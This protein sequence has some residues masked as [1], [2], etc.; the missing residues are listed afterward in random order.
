MTAAAADGQPAARPPA[1]HVHY[2]CVCG[3][4]YKANPLISLPPPPTFPDPGLHQLHL[5]GHRVPPAGPDRPHLHLR[6]PHHRPLGLHP[7]L[8]Q[9]AA[10]PVVVALQRLPAA[11]QELHAQV[12][13]GQGQLSGRHAAHPPH[14]GQPGAFPQCREPMTAAA[15]PVSFACFLFIGAVRRTSL[16]GSRFLGLPCVPQ[17]AEA[18]YLIPQFGQDWACYSSPSMTNAGKTLFFPLNSWRLCKC[19]LTSR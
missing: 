13:A 14:A 3:M 17:W 12:V 1:K 9:R 2:N 7:A 5:E 10:L 8:A 19:M 11:L 4:I 6:Q 15:F 16:G 18:P